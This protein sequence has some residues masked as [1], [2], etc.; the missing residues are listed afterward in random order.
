M[1]RLILVAGAILSAYAGHA[2]AQSRNFDIY[3][4]DVEGGAATLLVAP[5]GE[6]LTTKATGSRPR[7]RPAAR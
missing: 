7:S 6:S 1:K 4:I 5:S 2:L 3:W